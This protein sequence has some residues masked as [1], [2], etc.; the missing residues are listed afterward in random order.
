MIHFLQ[1][2]ASKK[3]IDE[4]LEVYPDVIKV[5]VDI[6]LGTLT[7]GGEMHADCESVLLE[8]GS[9]QMD[10]WGANWYPVER[11]T[12]FEALINIRPR[13]GNPRMVI[14]NEEIRRKVLQLT[15]KILAGK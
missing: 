12:A 10:I 14:Q 15:E 6:R 13:D 1:D 3:Q 7:G 5:A 2:A 11:R 9:E 8:N 4:M